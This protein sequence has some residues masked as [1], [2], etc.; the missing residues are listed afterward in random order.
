MMALS[1]AERQ[2]LYIQ[3]LRDRA[4]L[5]PPK[6]AA[7]PRSVRAQSKREAKEAWLKVR[8]ERRAYREAALGWR[9]RLEA[10]L[11]CAARGSMEPQM[12]NGL[13][14][15]GPRGIEYVKREA[16]EL[17]GIRWKP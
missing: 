8:A 1:N 5:P 6:M 3:R 7:S 13:P 16:R 17:F 10:L 15:H 2:R 14:I 12:L 4:G 11:I 9:Q